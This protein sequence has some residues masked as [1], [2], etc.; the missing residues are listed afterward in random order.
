MPEQDSIT[1]LN[2]TLT[3]QGRFRILGLKS[4]TFRNLA[5]V[6]VLNLFVF[7]LDYLACSFNAHRS[8]TF[9]DKYLA[10]QAR[11]QAQANRPKTMYD[12]ALNVDADVDDESGK[13]FVSERKE[14]NG[15]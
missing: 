5:S 9:H 3:A 6:P 13:W 12:Q 4:S 10:Q 15:R 1:T 14:S 7:L 11:R 2:E 8:L